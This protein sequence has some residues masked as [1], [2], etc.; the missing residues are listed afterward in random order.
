MIDD[1]SV[2]E[3]E[4]LENESSEQNLEREDLECMLAL[5]RVCDDEMSLEEITALLAGV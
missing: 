4:M 3:P 5:E 1:V 2:H